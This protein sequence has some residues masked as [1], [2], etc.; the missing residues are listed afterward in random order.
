MLVKLTR[1]DRVLCVVTDHLV[2]AFI[3]TV[4]RRGGDLGNSDV[5]AR[6]KRNFIVL[7]NIFCI[8]PMLPALVAQAPPGHRIATL[9]LSNVFWF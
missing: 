1:K 7:L 5:M 6:K 3:S 2:F 4:N 8:L 9:N